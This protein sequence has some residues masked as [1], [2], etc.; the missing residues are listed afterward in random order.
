[1]PR[2]RSNDTTGTNPCPAV[3]AGFVGW[4]DMIRT[5][6]RLAYRNWYVALLVC[7]GCSGSGPTEPSLPSVAGTYSLDLTP[8]SLQGGSTPT[9]PIHFVCR[10]ENRWT[11]SQTGTDIS[12]ISGSA[13][14]Q[15][16]PFDWNGAFTAKVERSGK[17]EITALTYRDSSSHSAIQ[18]L[19]LAGSGTVDS[20]GFAGMVAGNYT[21][22]STFGSATGPV[23]TC[24]GTQMPFRFSR[25]P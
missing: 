21:S 11:V 3:R 20:A 8:C 22:Q 9:V 24:H 15:C 19:A 12:G 4:H 1:M 13:A 7:C 18:T 23:V 2:P 10:S 14:G 17:V 5:R 16:A 6:G 25:Q